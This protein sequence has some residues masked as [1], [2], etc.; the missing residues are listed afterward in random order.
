[1]VSRQI[2]RVDVDAVLR[3]HAVNPLSVL[4]TPDPAGEVGWTPVDAYFVT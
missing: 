4:V 2:T 1:M 3:E